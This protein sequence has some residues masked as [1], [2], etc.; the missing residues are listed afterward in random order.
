[1]AN[2]GANK[3]K[4]KYQQPHPE[5]RYNALEVHRQ[6][7]CYR[8]W[9]NLIEG[10]NTRLWDPNKTPTSIW[11]WR[12]SKYLQTHIVESSWKGVAKVSNRLIC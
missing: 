7:S 10:R 2:H 11:N 3:G 12:S 5:D 8:Y 9:T 4:K 1:M 6:L